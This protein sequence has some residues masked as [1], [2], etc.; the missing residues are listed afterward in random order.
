MTDDLTEVHINTGDAVPKKQP[1]RRV[2]FAVR[3]EVAKQLQKMLR[4]GIIQPSSS[5]WASAI[6]LVRKK[7][8]SLRLCVDYRHLNSV[9][10]PDTFPLPRID[11]LLDQL[12]RARYFTTLDLAA[13]YWQIR[14]AD[15][16]IEK[17]A[18]VTPNGLF[19]FRVMPFGLTNAP[20][21]FQR[22]MQRVLNGL[23]PEEGPDFVAVYIDDI[24]IFSRTMSE[25]LHHVGL[26]LDCLQ[27]AGLK[28]KPNKCHFLCQRVEYLG[29]LVTPH[30]LEPNP[31]KVNAVT[32]FPVPTSTTQVRQ[33][34][35]LTSYYRR[36]IES[37]AK[38]AAPLHNLTRKDVEFRWT[39]ECQ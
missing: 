29:H 39:T 33:F 38:I 6:V 12:G 24:L 27:G 14:V 3:Q 23:N 20:A 35:G 31:K 21:I 25:H 32:Q 37:F 17:T 4:D 26:V 5:P 9:T 2:P 34:V 28:L 13:G 22:L 7:D 1:V 36:F 30:G 15:D 16:S 10:K 8:G 19:E 11:D 18:F